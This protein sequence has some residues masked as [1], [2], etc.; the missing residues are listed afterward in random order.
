MKSTYQ[1]RRR[2]GFTLVELLV[3]ITI[4][5]ILVALLL[6]AVQ[7]AREAARRAKCQNNLKQLGLAVLE[8]EE[9]WKIFPPSS[10]WAPGVVPQTRNPSDLRENWVIMILPF[11]E[12]QALLNSFDLTKPINHADNAPARATVLAVMLC[13]SDA[14]SREPFNGSHGNL[15]TNVGDNW[16]RGNY[17]ANASLAFMN[18]CTNSVNCGALP[19]SPGWTNSSYRGVMGANASVTMAEIK[20]GASNTILLGE[21]RAG[22]TDYD[23]RGVWAMSG[24]CPSALWCHG[25]IMGDDYGPNC[26]YFAAD[27]MQNCAQLRAEMGDPSFWQDQGNYLAQEG[28]P[29]SGVDVANIQQTARSMHAGGVHV[30]LADGSV[31]WLSDYIQVKP[32]S[33]NDPSVWDRLNAS[34]DTFSLS[35][36]TF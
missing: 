23:T 11:L 36:D 28:M 30:C 26:P 29:C 8:Y 32:S 3:V 19:T 12:Q 9:A 22:L 18:A 24:G 25:G 16:A 34:A 4:I 35:A 5:G 7:S 14:F 20:D 17:A 2:G 21:I 31:H 13:P 15:T 6:P 33:A 1:R 10:H 27:D